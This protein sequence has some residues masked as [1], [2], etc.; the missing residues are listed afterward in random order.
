MKIDPDH[1]HIVRRA[2]RRLD[3][4]NA[5][6]EM[7]VRL[8]DVE[9]LSIIRS[10]CG[11][12]TLRVKCTCDAY[13]KVV[14]FTLPINGRADLQD[15]LEFAVDDSFCADPAFDQQRAQLNA[16]RSNL[17]A[18]CAAWLEHDDMPLH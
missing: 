7:P 6:P 16:W 1:D 14:T 8:L 4:L 12:P 18:D 11:H 5:R 3:E 17:A 2:G 10:E 13:D 15:L 9:S